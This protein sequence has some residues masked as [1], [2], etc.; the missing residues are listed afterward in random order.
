MHCY[1]EI[2]AQVVLEK[3]LQ[4]KWRENDEAEYSD[5]TEIPEAAHN[6]FANF[7]HDA[8]KPTMAAMDAAVAALPD[9][10]GRDENAYTESAYQKARTLARQINPRRRDAR[11]HPRYGFNPFYGFENVDIDAK[12]EK[13]QSI[14]KK[15]VRYRI[16]NGEL[17]VIEA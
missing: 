13:I 4:Q 9:G 8:F 12:M 1:S 14:L 2:E 6:L 3:I 15:E 17:I 7:R 5:D 16:L 10:I 11:N